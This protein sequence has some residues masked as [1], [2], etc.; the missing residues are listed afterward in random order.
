[1]V[2][3]IVELRGAVGR[4]SVVGL[5][6]EELTAFRRHAATWRA[7]TARDPESS[8]HTPELYA[9]WY[10][11]KEF[12]QRAIAENPFGT[13]KFVWCDAGI[14]RYPE[15]IP[16]IMSFPRSERV[17]AGKVNV[18]QV[19]P[20][21]SGD[22]EKHADGLCGDFQRCVR[23]GGGILGSDVAGWR[24]WDAAYEDMFRRYL[25]AGRFV[26]KDQEIM[27]SMI[28]D[29][30]TLVEIIRP[31]LEFDSHQAWFF[32]LWYYAGCPMDSA[33]PWPDELAQLIKSSQQKSGSHTGLL[34]RVR[35]KLH[36]LLK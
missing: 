7:A 32:L 21:Q 17:V 11:K 8:V 24:R 27:A 22:Y 14:S 16:Y 31:P 28:L 3:Q 2:Q 1:L 10:E 30:P 25:D 26:G 36:R 13:E 20:F 6:F 33:M 23:I 15:W 12:V 4:T 5:A 19:I 35:A 9:I 34:N 18:L 29:D